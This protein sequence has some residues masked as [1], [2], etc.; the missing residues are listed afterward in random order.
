MSDLLFMGAK[1]GVGTSTVAAIAALKLAAKGER[2]N[3]VTDN[4]G[5]MA[6]IFGLPVPDPDHSAVELTENIT[7]GAMSS[8]R[9]NIIDAG[10]TIP[11]GFEGE[12]ILVIRNCYLSLRRAMQM[13]RPSAVVMLKEPNRALDE[14]DAVAILGLS[15]NVMPMSDS[16][17]RAIDA[18]L[19]Q[20]RMPAALRDFQIVA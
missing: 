9:R 2:V 19:L 15:V 17:A 11:E 18:G 7:M 8:V 14:S 13:P 1:G 20:H 16:V 3:I 6:A 10:T 5:D 12:V 4:F